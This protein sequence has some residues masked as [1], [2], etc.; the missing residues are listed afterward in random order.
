MQRGI[1]DENAEYQL[2]GRQGMHVLEG[3]LNEAEV[4][5]QAADT[6][7]RNPNN[8][9]VNRIQTP[10]EAFVRF[11][12]QILFVRDDPR[13]PVLIAKSILSSGKCVSLRC[14]GYARIT[15]GLFLQ[16]S[17][18]DSLMEFFNDVGSDPSR[19]SLFELVAQEQLRDLLQPAL[20]YVL[21]VWLVPK[22][23]NSMTERHHRSSPSGILAT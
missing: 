14:Y 5:K 15:D 13:F 19:P 20:K 4:H 10:T 16:R 1:T 2:A 22:L 9:S 12:M 21:S 6:R 8:T 17:L 18:P 23:R 7:Q 11:R 3:Q